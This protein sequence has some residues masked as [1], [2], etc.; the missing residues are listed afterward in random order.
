MTTLILPVLN[1]PSTLAN[2]VVSLRTD[3]RVPQ[4]Q[5]DLFLSHHK[6]FIS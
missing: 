5:R 6:L 4:C 1:A 3:S 2:V